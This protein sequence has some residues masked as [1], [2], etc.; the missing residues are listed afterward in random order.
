MGVCE[1]ERGAY[2]EER[3]TVSRSMEGWERT[4][5]VY[6]YSYIYHKLVRWAGVS[7]SER[8]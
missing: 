6:L 2:V 8:E 4:L 3:E 5:L 1:S 7:V